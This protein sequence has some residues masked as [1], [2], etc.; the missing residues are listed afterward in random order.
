MYKPSLDAGEEG[1]MWGTLLFCDATAYQTGQLN[2]ARLLS[3]YLWHPEIFQ[4]HLGHVDNEG[5]LNL[6]SDHVKSYMTDD[7]GRDCKWT[8]AC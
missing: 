7:R 3:P 5:T 2:L 4:N 8:G 1:L 6:L